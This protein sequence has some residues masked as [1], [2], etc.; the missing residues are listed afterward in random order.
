MNSTVYCF[1]KLN[2]I[3]FLKL[4]QQYYWGEG[5]IS[6]KIIVSRRGIDKGGYWD[7]EPGAKNAWHRGN[8]SSG[9]EES[10]NWIP[11]WAWQLTQRKSW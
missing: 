1:Y 10:R 5:E 8:L 4:G 6:G 7:E 9:K 2:I 3:F 11:T